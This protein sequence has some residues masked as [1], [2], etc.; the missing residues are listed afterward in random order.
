M[1]SF[2][3]DLGLPVGPGYVPQSMKPTRPRYS[4]IQVQTFVCA[5]M[6][7]TEKSTGWYFAVECRSYRDRPLAAEPFVKERRQFSGP[8]T[9][10]CTVA[11]T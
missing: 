4:D 9:P 8:F 11:I 5:L 6:G 1:L 2:L 10:D 7:S 3:T